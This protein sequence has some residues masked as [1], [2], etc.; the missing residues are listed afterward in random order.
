M[1][2]SRITTAIFTLAT[3]A[4]PAC[5]ASPKTNPTLEQQPSEASS[6]RAAS[7]AAPA[8]TPDAT[9]AAPADIPPTTKSAPPEAADKAPRPAGVPTDWQLV[10]ASHGLSFW[11]PAPWTVDPKGSAALVT[12][13]G[14]LEFSVPA[15]EILDRPEFAGAASELE[16]LAVAEAKKSAGDRKV[17]VK[18]DAARGEVAVEY[19]ASGDGTVVLERW[20]ATPTGG[21]GLTC[22]DENGGGIAG[23]RQT[24]DAILQSL[25]RSG[26]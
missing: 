10:S 9:P 20:I 17:T 12:T 15:C 26:H 22:I 25:Q 4:G 7:V 24:L 23:T 2:I 8:A 16:A 3:A 21:V 14:G 6:P 11:V 19:K 5:D 13:K 18:R 1:D